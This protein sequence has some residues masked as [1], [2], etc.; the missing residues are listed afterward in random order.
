MQATQ[1]LLTRIV[2]LTDTSKPTSD[3][4][5]A[6]ER[7]SDQPP[8]CI[9][10]RCVRIEREILR[11]TQRPFG[12]RAICS[13]EVGLLWIGGEGPVSLLEESNSALAVIWMLVVYSVVASAGS[14]D[15]CSRFI[16]YCVEQCS[17]FRQDRCES[18]QVAS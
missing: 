4:T 13:D 3:A 10:R 8:R 5:Q 2:Q 7:L 1:I 15:E 16:G 6:K 17:R 11:K 18:L 14:L 9:A 12:L